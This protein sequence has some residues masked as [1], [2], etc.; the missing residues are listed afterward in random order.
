[1]STEKVGQTRLSLL[2]AAERLFSERG[3]D[4]VSLREIAEVAKQR[5]HAAAAYH[6]GDKRELIEQLLARHSGIVDDGF[7]PALDALRA[8]GRESLRTI[9]ACLVQPMV[10]ILDDD[11][12]GVDYLLICA[13]LVNSQ[14]FPITS[15]RAA[16]GP[17]AMEL[18]MRMLAFMP[19]MDPVVL[20][21]RMTRTAAVLFYSIA[22]YHR[23]TSAGVFV[24]R[25]KFVDDLIDS[26][27]ALSA[28]HG[29]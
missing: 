1:M 8:E 18:T 23:L 24:P 2:R 11:D 19:E 12:G 28:P 15:L 5:N 17:G 13:Q 29:L 16:N 20:P 9:V 7:V 21:L 27:V 26:L 25:D 22:S 14:T 10:A 3:V 6:F 4:N